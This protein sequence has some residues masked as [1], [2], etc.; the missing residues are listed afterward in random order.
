MKCSGVFGEG[1]EEGRRERDRREEEREKK[2]AET[3]ERLLK[4]LE[5]MV[6][7]M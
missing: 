6:A 7:K 3:D 4:L 2:E 5:R 1:R